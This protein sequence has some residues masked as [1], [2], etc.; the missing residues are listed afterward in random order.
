LVDDGKIENL[1]ERFLNRKR[2]T[3]VLAFLFDDRNKKGVWGEIYIS[4]ERAREQ[5]VNYGVTFN[6]ELTRL[7]IHGILHLLGYNDDTLKRSRIMKAREEFYL[8]RFE[9]GVENIGS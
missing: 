2:P 5:A 7:I 3:D 4:E 9:G 6:N 1:N 8:A